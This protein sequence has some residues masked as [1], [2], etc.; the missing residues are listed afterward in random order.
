MRFLTVLTGLILSFV[1]P[2]AAAGGQLVSTVAPAISPASG[3]YHQ[4]QSVTIS[5]SATGAIIYYTL[6]GSIPTTS[7]L[8]YGGN[9]NVSTN[10]TVNAIAV[11]GSNPPSSVT[12]ATYA[13][14][15]ATASFTPGSGTYPAGQPVSITSFTSGAKIYYTTDGS[16]PTTSSNL[17]AAP[18]VVSVSEKLTAI[19][20]ATGYNNSFPSS[21]TYQ[22]APPAATPTFSPAGG[23]YTS[24]Q[25][26]TLSDAT[27]GAAIYYTTNGSK[28][29][30]AS[31]LYAGPISVGASETIQAVAFASGSSLSSVAA[32][33]Y[34]LAFPAAAP[35]ISPAA[36]I[37]SI[38]QT[39][40][41]ADTT[42]NAVVYYTLDGSTPSSS[43]S[44][45]Y[46]PFSVSKNTTVQAI[47]L[48][49]GGSQSPVLNAAYTILA[50]T[51]YIQPAGGA[52]QS[53]QTVTMSSIAGASIY[54]TTNGATP[55]TSS[56]LYTGPI[57]VSST[58]TIT[59]FAVAQ[60]NGDSNP[61]AVTFT[62]NIAAAPPTFSPAA[63]QY[64]SAQTVA[65]S[66]TT[67]GAQIYYTTNGTTPSTASTPY[68]GPISVGANETIQAVA[69][70]TG[71]SLSPVATAAYTIALPAALPALSAASGT[72]HTPPTVTITDATPNAV[73]Y[74]T[75]DGST[76]TTSSPVYT[77]P[78]TI[79]DNSTLQ[80]MALA[81]NG[82]D[83]PVATATYTVLAKTPYIEPA[84]GT[85]TTPQTVVMTSNAGA[86]IYYTT[87][88][89]TPTTAS[90]LFAGPF[91]VSS[92]VTIT[93]IAVD[94]GYGNS[95]VKSVTYKI[96]IQASAPVISPSGGQYTSVQ[97]VTLS[98]ATSGAQ[99]YYTT[100]GSTPTSSSS[101]YSGPLTVS[102]NETVSAI[103]LVSGGT[104]SAVTSANFTIA[105][106]AAAPTFSPAPGT[107]PNAQTVTLADAT[108]GAQIFYTTN[109]S[110]PTSSSTL[111]SGPISVGATETIQAVAL[112]SGGSLSPVASAA[113]A[114]TQ[115]ST[116][117]VINPGTGTYNSAQTV[118]ISDDYSNA[119]IY[120]TTNGT[121]PTTSSTK[122]SGPVTV[123]ANS[124]IE[125]IAT[126]SG[127]P[128]SS[129]AA[130]T[131][132]F[133]AGTP[134][135]SPAGGTYAASQKVTISSATSGAMIYY[136]TDGTTPT[137]AS[138][139]YSAPLT[140]SSSETV[141]AIAI[142]K[143]Y[144]NSSVSSAAYTIAPAAPTPVISPAAGTYSK[145]L[146]VSISCTNKSAV[147]YYTT[148][149]S[150]PTPNSPVYS[151]ALTVDQNQTVKAIALASG[152]S[153]S[154][155]STAAYTI[156]LPAA[157]PTFSPVGAKY[158]SVQ[159]VTI[160]D[161]TA[162]A[163]IHY[164][165][166][167]STPT[168]ASTLYT[169]PITVGVTET[170][171]AVAIA[172]GGSLGSVAKAGYTITLP[173]AVPV[174]S[175]AGGTYNSIQKVTISDATPGAVIY[176]TV[177]GKFP[178]TND[179]VYTGQTIT[180]TTTTLVQAIA[181]APTDSVS[182]G[183]SEQYDIVVPAPTIT[184]DAGTFDYSVTVTM[185]S[186]VP[187]A[188]IYYNTNGF[189]PT[190]SSNL[191]TGPIVLAPTQTSS[192]T[193]LA[194]AVAPGF[195]ESPESTATVTET[196]PTGVI[197]EASIGTTPQMTIP[198][199]FLGLSDDYHTPQTLMGQT[200]TGENPA[201]RQL[202]KN[203]T[204]YYTAPLLFRI[205]ADNV[206][207]ADLQPDIEPLV[208]LAQNVN[209]KYTLGVDMWQNDPVMSEAEAVQWVDGIPNN[210]IQAIEIGNEPDEYPYNGAR[211]A[212]YD[213][214]AYLA[215]FQL[216]KLG[217]QTL[218]GTNFG[219]MGPSMAASGWKANAET[220]FENLTLAPVIGSQHAYCG[221]PA[222][223]QTL[224]PDYM[225]E[226][227][228][229]TKLPGA[230]APL[231][232]AAHAA[233]LNFRM[234]EI[235]SIGGG[236]V[237]G[238][239]DTFTTA[240]WAPDIMFN[241]L[242][243]GMDGVN[244]HSDQ[245]TIYRPYNFSW[246][247]TNGK[248][249]YTLN[250]VNPDYYGLLVFAQM[251][252]RGAQLLP[253][254]PITDSNVSIWATVDNTST[255]H[256]LVINKDEAATGDVVINLP[257]YTKGTVRYL[258]APA[259][260]SKTGVTFGGQT[261]DGST[262]GTIQG[263]LVTSTITAQDGVFTLPAMPV[264]A[265]AMIDFSN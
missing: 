245:V 43:S 99:I 221:G 69:I 238:I 209:V 78:V 119:V 106:P 93:A 89:T 257:G 8:V 102:T 218:V 26:V 262:D 46:G 236:G 91:V 175:P 246:K 36:G 146:T 84:S 205:S 135:F 64:T 230:Y 37:Y 148:D 101:V 9:L 207:P 206:T 242:I 231:A 22:I 147:I 132:T 83:S 215:E 5:D 77:Q 169:G 190:T 90:T 109:G 188:Q 211:T 65:L 7:S 11:N 94:S 152:G 256:V 60:G 57:T 79:A 62:I 185:S 131:Y 144:G 261:F 174:I 6:D 130:A 133:V 87:D 240:L 249:T 181:Q 95:S 118:T 153:D 25:S 66:D 53:A 162:N 229:A 252:G 254:T 227:I 168:T 16:T 182:N 136:T 155:V 18:V 265:A 31:T 108:S 161:A 75:L 164:T 187:G 159:T 38:A 219:S 72:Y 180:A 193:F 20:V 80:A 49:P 214:T 223:G 141:H 52:Y 204:Q 35:T 47:A 234:G 134:A 125:A 212:A 122:Y 92:S 160:S 210:L 244:W 166:D 28:P 170:I 98:D 23:Q 220:A 45:Y 100:N 120:Y 172:P 154:P 103:A 183:A 114:I 165:L 10:T 177:N 29:T 97:T 239:S 73:I 123:T 192:Q 247:T 124:T 149:G 163:A 203:L 21:A 54:Y 27:S 226:P 235:N 71:G 201:Y 51:P 197:A 232:A 228:N 128:T 196:L 82:S 3:T 213:W 14:P 15:A 167:G 171:S 139:F 40:T 116:T 121:T 32:A 140:V 142:L 151:A 217:I 178:T 150:T 137:S 42:A 208:E 233:G 258:Q 186:P 195:N 117:P 138:S 156:T 222:A 105:L 194:I 41:L 224:P 17:Y 110:A 50:A 173:T 74:F 58:E 129:T 255:A 113:Y 157:K 107:Y 24:V 81:P 126:V 248:T 76:P 198:P 44:I 111:Y 251:A 253:V 33:S 202:L 259:I 179:P 4:A 68:T 30:T 250:T 2:A 191:Y 127:M 56:T 1:V 143:N 241:Y 39:V 260:T 115:S 63:G 176:Y 12:T 85:Y 48:A 86:S 88:G 200:S 225:L 264:T 158:T 59:A 34:T 104:A 263:K 199:N 237:E 13:F 189:Y 96:G 243:N 67:S 112:A 70:A 184:P 61:K 19:A 55:T 216:W 145:V